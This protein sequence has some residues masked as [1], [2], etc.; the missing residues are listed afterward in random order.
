MHAPPT[1]PS[2]P[3]ESAPQRPV[4]V[5]RLYDHLGYAG[6]VLHG[7]GRTILRTTPVFDRTRVHLT[8]H[9]VG[10]THPAAVDLEHAG[11]PVEFFGCGKWSLSALP[12]M[13]TLLRRTQ[14]DVLHLGGMRAILLGRIAARM[15]GVPALVHFHDAQPVAGPIRLAQRALARWTAAAL[16]VS[17]AVGVS[18]ARRFG[19][20]PG[21]VQ[22]I[23]NG[24]DLAIFGERPPGEAAATRA[25]CGW[26]AAHRVVAMVG[27][28]RAEKSAD[29]VVNGLA[30]LRTS[31]PS[32]RLLLVGDGPARNALEAQVAAA[33]LAD[34]VYFAG[35]QADVPRW[36]AA[37]DALALPTVDGEGFPIAG[38]EAMAAGL[39]VV[40]FRMGGLPELVQ[41]GHEGWLAEPG[42]VDGLAEGL[43]QVLTNDDLR[44]QMARAA[45]ARART[46]TLEAHVRALEDVYL[47]VAGTKRRTRR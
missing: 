40:G 22:T 7:P 29:L 42:D 25:A 3:P 36:L 18:A 9:F 46:F 45:R 5:V 13:L 32:I 27:R 1:T 34:R 47:G 19:F 4:R 16:A 41:H 33:G 17:D 10:P 15:R 35:F 31:A 11:H 14:P 20:A 23:Y 30:T 21:F 38:I 37:A 39:P 6:G 26:S 24:V 43:R 28:L 12:R 2:R 8:V 44:A